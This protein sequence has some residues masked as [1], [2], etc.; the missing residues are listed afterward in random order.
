MY[1]EM[2]YSV[3][4]VMYIFSLKIDTILKLTETVFITS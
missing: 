3:S 2:F 1:S 4:V